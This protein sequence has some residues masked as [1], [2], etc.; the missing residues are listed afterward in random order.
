VEQRERGEREGQEARRLQGVIQGLEEEGEELKKESDELKKRLA[1]AEEAMSDTEGLRER[2]RDKRAQVEMELASLMCK[3]E[4]L[5]GDKEALVDNLAS[6]RLEN[7]GLKKH[8]SGLSSENDDLR[9]TLERGRGESLDWKE[10]A[11][12]LQEENG[13][14][15]ADVEALGRELSLFGEVES[16]LEQ[17]REA[18]AKQE[19]EFMRL[20]GEKDEEVMRLRKEKDEEVM[21]LSSI[22]EVERDA[23]LDHVASLSGSLQGSPHPLQILAHPTP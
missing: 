14:L 10:R 23:H 22:L 12:N 13:R 5:E 17:I 8:A 7:D 2:E 21:R 11:H 3:V 16:E 1:R 19:E 9:Q 18:H 20:K 15:V 6:L 4:V